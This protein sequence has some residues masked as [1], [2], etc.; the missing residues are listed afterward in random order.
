MV[1]INKLK[2]LVF[3]LDDLGVKNAD[4]NA[5]EMRTVFVLVIYQA[6]FLIMS[7]GILDT[8]LNFSLIQYVKIIGPPICCIPLFIFNYKYFISKRGF[9][10]LQEQYHNA[11]INSKRN[12]IIAAIA[13]V[14]ILITIVALIC[15]T[16]YLFF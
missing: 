14:V 2:F 16:K 7:F 15:S 9:E 1:K 12:R 8:L 11:G 6:L 5:D 3:A 10:K 4:R 13:W